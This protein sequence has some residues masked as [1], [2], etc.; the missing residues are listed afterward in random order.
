MPTISVARAG[1]FHAAATWACAVDGIS[2]QHRPTGAARNVLRLWVVME[3][4]RNQATAAD[5]SGKGQPFFESG[6]VTNWF[7]PRP[8]Y[9]VSLD[10]A[11]H[12]PVNSRSHSHDATL[13]RL[14]RL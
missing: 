6:H 12:F 7:E 10:V 3:E 5:S 14:H 9:G 11:G 4:R 1:S 8:T 2:R 13:C